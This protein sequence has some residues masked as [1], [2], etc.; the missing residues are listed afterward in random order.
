VSF[1]ALPH[2]AWPN[3]AVGLAQ[4]WH[5]D[6]ASHDLRWYAAAHAVHG[7]K[8]PNVRALAERW[9][10]SRWKAHTLLTSGQWMDHARPWTWAAPDKNRTTTGQEPD[11]KDGQTPNSNAKPDKS[12]TTT[13]QEPDSR[14]RSSVH[15]SP[16]TQEPEPADAAE[17]TPTTEPAHG[18]QPTDPPPSESRP[19]ASSPTDGGGGCPER[20]EQATPAGQPPTGDP[21]PE[22]HPGR[23]GPAV[24]AWEVI[25]AIRRRNVKGAGKLTMTAAMGKAM[26]ERMQEHS[27][28]DLA[29]MVEWVTGCR[30]G[31]PKCRACSWLQPK[32]YTHPK[33]YLRPDN[34]SEYLD[35]A[36]QAGAVAPP[37]GSAPVDWTESDAARLVVQRVL[38]GGDL[39]H[40]D[41]RILWLAKRT[42]SHIGKRAAWRGK[43]NTVEWISAWRKEWPASVA[44]WEA[45]QEQA[46]AAK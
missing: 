15:P 7:A 9:G 25:D 37:V 30:C 18:H 21:R 10:W 41:E 32:G 35:L 3:I 39:Y 20:G 2:L 33:T 6:A 45:K 5:A 26:K 19:D 24:A 28:D 29:L 44:A 23:A 42:I 11:T 22:P 4:P 31:G 38:D 27:A 43:G 1:D 36:K 17:P 40:R 12:R 34:C 13:G 8:L 14:A 46:G 16:H